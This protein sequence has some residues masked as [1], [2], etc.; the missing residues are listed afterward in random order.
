MNFLILSEVIDNLH[1]AIIWR[2][3]TFPLGFVHRK[4][5]VFGNLGLSIMAAIPLSWLIFGGCPWT[6]FANHFRELGGVASSKIPSSFLAT[7]V[8]SLTSLSISENII[9]VSGICLGLFALAY[10]LISIFS[11]KIKN[12]INKYEKSSHEDSTQRPL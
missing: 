9:V 10:F 4:T 6:I 5:R 3:V 12:L 7:K 8:N 1:W 11:S 2:R